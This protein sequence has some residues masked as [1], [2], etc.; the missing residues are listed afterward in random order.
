MLK[1]RDKYRSTDISVDLYLNV[2]FNRQQVA[3]RHC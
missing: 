2:K 3:A 1:Y